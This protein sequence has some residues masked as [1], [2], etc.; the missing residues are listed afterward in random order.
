MLRS[1]AALVGLL[2]VGILA[3]LA[4]VLYRLVDAKPD[5]AI[6]WLRAIWNAVVAAEWVSLALTAVVGIGCVAA[7]RN[8]RWSRAACVYYTAVSVVAV[9]WVPFALYWDFLWPVW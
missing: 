4:T 1:S 6:A 3:T 9:G 2:N 7:W 5:P 8:N